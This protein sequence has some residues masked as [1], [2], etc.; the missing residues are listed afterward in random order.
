[1]L[2]KRGRRS[3]RHFRISFTATKPP[4]PLFFCV[5]LKLRFLFWELRSKQFAVLILQKNFD[6]VCIGTVDCL[7]FAAFNRVCRLGSG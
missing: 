3:G 5:S 4:P 1:M 6:L 7:V 2:E